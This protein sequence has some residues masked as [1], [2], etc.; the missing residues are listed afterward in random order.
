MH[1]LLSISN[2]PPIRSVHVTPGQLLATRRGG[3]FAWWD[4]HKSYLTQN[5]FSSS[6]VSRP[7]AFQTRLR[8]RLAGYGLQWRRHRPR[9][10]LGLSRSSSK[11]SLQL[12]C[13]VLPLC[14]DIEEQVLLRYYGLYDA[15]R[16][17]GGNDL[18]NA[19]PGSGK[20]GPPF[21]FG[22]LF[23]AGENHHHQIEELARVGL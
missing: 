15:F 9:K 23:P 22:A 4:D 8:R 18:P 7:A 12:E 6:A 2:L 19:E 1:K 17:L 10:D 16:S 20:Q 11:P 14:F 21:R 13:I 3:N 5:L